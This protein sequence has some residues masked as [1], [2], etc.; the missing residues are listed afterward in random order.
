MYIKSA[1][2]YHVN[3]VHKKGPRIQK[4]FKENA[5]ENQDMKRYF[6][7]IS[8]KMRG[9]QREREGEREIFPHNGILHHINAMK[10]L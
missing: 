7:F 8:R 5:R 10:I 2:V 4:A 9:G 6:Y 1:H 3:G